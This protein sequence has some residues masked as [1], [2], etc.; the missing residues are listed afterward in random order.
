MAGKTTTKLGGVSNHRKYLI[1]S[2]SIRSGVE[3]SWTRM[4]EYYFFTFSTP[5]RLGLIHPAGKIGKVDCIAYSS[6][7]GRLPYVGTC[8]QI[9]DVLARVRDLLAEHERC[10][11]GVMDN[12]SLLL[13]LARFAQQAGGRNKLRL[14]HFFHGHSYGFDRGRAEQ[15]YGAA[16]LWVYLTD[17]GYEHDLNRYHTMPCR[18]QVL[19]NGIDKSS[20]HPLGEAQRGPLRERLWPRHSLKFLWVSA[21]R[22]KKGLDVL[23]AAWPRIQ[24]AYPEAHLKVI[25]G[26]RERQEGV[27]FLGYQPNELLSQFYQ[28]TDFY[29]FTSLCQEGFPLSLAEA[30]CSGALC[31][32]STLGG[33]AHVLADDGVTVPRPHMV[34]AWVEATEKAVA[35]YRANGNRNPFAGKSSV[36]FKDL[37]TWCHELEGVF[38]SFD[39]PMG[40]ELAPPPAGSAEPDRAIPPVPAT[41]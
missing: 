39:P 26:Y 18:V 2:K 21:D 31:I 8:F 35:L 6:W 41:K 25:G 27:E 3:G 40:A 7:R 15:V 16:D 34:S 23:L 1:S 32:S 10:V 19:E 29:Y 14:I 11:L 38:A 9:A 17:R 28:T 5:R 30:L 13:A 24:Q 37:D 22:K 12:C 33:S 4:L 36:R 20:F